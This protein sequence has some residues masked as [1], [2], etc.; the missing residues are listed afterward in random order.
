M[1]SPPTHGLLP[2]TLTPPGRRPRAPARVGSQLYRPTSGTGPS[3]A[4]EQDLP[5]T[6]R[7]RYASTTATA[8]DQD[9]HT[10][11]RNSWRWSRDLAAEAA[12]RWAIHL[13]HE[14]HEQI[15]SRLNDLR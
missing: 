11:A 13:P 6:D 1:H 4:L 7:H 10:A 5:D 15:S 2:S 3:R 12:D 9:V 14:L 8:H